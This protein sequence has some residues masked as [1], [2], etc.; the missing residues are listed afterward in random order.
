MLIEEHLGRPDRFDMLPSEF[1]VVCWGSV[2]ST[3]GVNYH[4]FRTIEGK[5]EKRRA[6]CL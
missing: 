3:K 5:L 4:E 2:H 1:E 6:E